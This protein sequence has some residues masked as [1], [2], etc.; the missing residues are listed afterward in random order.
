LGP[1]REI[2]PNR[3]F[4]APGP[5]EGSRPVPGYRGAPARGVDVK[6]PSAR[7]PGPGPGVPGG[8]W[9]GQ[10]PLPGSGTSRRTLR[11]PSRGPGSPSRASRSEGFTST[12]RA[13]AP[14]F[15][16]ARAPG[17]PGRGLWSRRG[18]PPPGRGRGRSPLEHPQALRGRGCPEGRGTGVS[19]DSY[20]W[21]F[22]IY[23]S[24]CSPKL[25]NA[26]P[27]RDEVRDSGPG[28]RPVP[29]TL[30]QGETPCPSSGGYPAP[31]RRWLAT[32]PP[33]GNRGAPARGVDVKPPLSRGP[34]EAPGA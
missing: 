28:G 19:G 25:F 24:C 16:A 32:P 6:P 11:G 27:L 20:R 23:F 12:P 5:R 4:G 21:L 33:P 18:Y 8:P 22:D 29:A 7:G 31:G 13:G 34:G 1:F 30:P 17:A 26:I 2:S 10:D 15:P 9:P 3:G 14:R